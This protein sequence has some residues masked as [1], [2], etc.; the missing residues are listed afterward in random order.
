[1]QKFAKEKKADTDHSIYFIFSFFNVAE[2][3]II[4]KLIYANLKINR[5]WKEKN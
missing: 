3:A 5:V 2:V 4:Y 1:V